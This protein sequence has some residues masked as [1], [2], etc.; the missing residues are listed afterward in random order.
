M[1]LLPAAI[2]AEAAVTR[3][4]VALSTLKASADADKQIANL[5]EDTLLNV[6]SGSRGGN[7]NLTA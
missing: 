3:Q 6:P 4:N 7:V 2:A 1:D 5:L